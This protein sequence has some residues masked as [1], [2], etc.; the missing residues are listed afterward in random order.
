MS[1]Q[2]RD[3]HRGPEA[4]SRRENSHA[5]GPARNDWLPNLVK[6]SRIDVPGGA[7]AASSARKAILEQFGEI[8]APDERDVLRLLATELVTNAVLH[9]GADEQHH[10]I[11][12]LAAAPHR[13]RVE[14]CDG[15]PGLDPETLPRLE[16]TGGD[17]LILLN[18]L[19]SRWGLSTDNGTCVWFELD[20]TPNEA[21]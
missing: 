1:R 11:L 5:Y 18:A 15:G 16:E 21:D 17:G 12:H 4:L 7:H 19:A 8:L 9:G 13:V 20:R 2:P 10:V 14:V 6:D 3:V